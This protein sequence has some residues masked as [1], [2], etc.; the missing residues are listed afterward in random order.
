MSEN[1]REIGP[2]TLLAPLPAVLVSCGFGGRQNLLTVAWTGVVNSKPPMVSVSIKPERFS[3]DLIRDSGEFVVNLPGKEMLDALDFCGVRSGREKDKFAEAHLAAIPAV[4]LSQAPAVR[5]A[6]ASLS[7]KVRHMMPL[8]SHDL[9]IG[10][11]TGIQVRE[12]LFDPD[13]SLHLERAELICYSHGLY[14]CSG[15][16]LGFFGCSVARPEVRE[17]RMLPYR[18]LK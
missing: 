11:V 16:V 8:G 5:G 18:S 3:H 10:E 14:Q 2:C 6:A 7:C 4:H 12:D 1:Y 13:G 9:F 17:R 15:E